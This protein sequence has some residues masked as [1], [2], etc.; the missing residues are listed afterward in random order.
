MPLPEITNLAQRRGLFTPSAEIYANAPAGFWDYG[1]E[2][3]RIKRRL[4][5]HWRKTLI[6]K[7]GNIEIEGSTLLPEIVFKAS[8]HLENFND[9]LV[10]CETC[11]TPYRADKLIEEK[12]E[13]EIPEGASLDFF[14]QKIAELKLVC[15]KDKKPFGRTTKFNL[16]MQVN[17]GATHGN[18]SY[19]RPEA[20]QSIFLAFPRIWKS[21]RIKLPIGIGQAGKAYRNEIAPRQGLLRTREFEQM[22]MEIFFN[23]RKINEIEKWEEVKEYALNLYLLSDKQTHAITCE[24]AVEQKIVS[25]KIIAYYLA[26]TQQFFASLHIPLEKIRFRE[27]EKEARAFYARETWDLEVQ[28]DNAWIELAACNY[29]GEHDLKTHG[30]ESKQ[31]ITIKEDGENEKY[32]PHIFEISIGVDRTFLVML[33]ANLRK[34]IRGT[35]ERTYL[36]LPKEIAPYD[37]SV[38]PLMKKDGLA[39]HAEELAHHLRGQNI[40]VIYDETGSIGKRYARTDEIGIPYAITVDYQSL[41]D[42]SITLRERSSMKQKRVQVDD[43]DE[44]FWKFSTNQKKFEDL[45]D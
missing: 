4:V 21:G 12:L 7:E 3:T 33:D 41:Q 15:P 27:L 18:V 2:G 43:L 16:M 26:R 29:R 23:P 45:A 14:D 25:G 6:H 17:I 30:E 31:D 38:F 39:E 11:K 42:R 40:A 44:I 37:V 8:G 28:M 24:E 36:D 10:I 13:H 20:C 1:N 34:E 35:E 22:D 32:V 19:L 9:P 5:E